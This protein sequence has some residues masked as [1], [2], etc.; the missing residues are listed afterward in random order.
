VKQ[1][2]FITSLILLITSCGDKENETIDLSD[3]IE[4]SDRYNEDSTNVNGK[5]NE[6]DT[7]AQFLEDF[8]S[9]GITADKLLVFED[10]YFPDRL[11]PID[12]KK[13]ELIRD[14]NTF[15]FIQWNFKDSTK[16]MN[17]FFNWMDCF[18]EKCKSIFIG[19]ERIFQN[20]PFQLLVN[21][22]AL[23][24]IEGIESFDF[25]EWENYFVEKG[26]PLDWNYV[27]EQRKRGKAHWF[28]YIEEKK[29]P[30]KNENS[31]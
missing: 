1:L 13:F 3:I 15:R 31:K 25:K 12:T 16:V 19:E 9:H 14:D 7:L 4:G 24:F 29:T 23:V 2:I 20:N 10:N 8:K 17:A 11:G 28:N 5:P 22:S 18:G 21:D 27:I 30:F 6:L 26:V